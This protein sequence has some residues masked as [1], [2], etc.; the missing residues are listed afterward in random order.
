[1]T[2]DP[3]A[4]PMRF[5]LLDKGIAPR[6]TRLACPGWAGAAVRPKDG[7]TPQPWHCAPFAEGAAYG[8]EICYPYDTECTVTLVDGK[9]CV[10]GEFAREI[11]RGTEWPPVIST[12]PGHYSFGALV[13]IEAGPGWLLRVEPH[14][15]YF[16]DR[17]GEVAPAVIGNLDTAWWPMFMFLTFKAPLEGQTHRFRRGDP[18]AQVIAVPRRP[19]DLRIMSAD[20]ARQR[21]RSAQGIMKERAAIATRS[22]TSEDGL[23]FD[24]VYRQLARRARE[25][26]KRAPPH[27]VRK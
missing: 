9:P 14:P 12:N 24:D 11:V 6:R 26:A 1:M 7:A 3:D 25:P 18:V 2:N 21:E 13:D 5:R 23:A 17:L 10:A 22:W 20:E 19:A 8:Y 16:T 27:S 4:A 15:R